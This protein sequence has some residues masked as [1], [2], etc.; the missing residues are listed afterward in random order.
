MSEYGHDFRPDYLKLGFIRQYQGLRDVPIL[1]L[2]ATAVPR[3]QS[4]IFRSLQ[5]RNPLVSMKSF[6]RENLIISVKSKPSGG[7]SQAFSENL[8]ED[9]IQANHNGA[10][11]ENGGQSTI[12]SN[13]YLMIF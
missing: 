1:A 13:F 7:F 8:V 3:V 5:L 12:V 11:N 10:L 4:D 2:T 6:D 9:L